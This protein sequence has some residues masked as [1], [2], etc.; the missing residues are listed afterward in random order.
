[1]ATKSIDTPRRDDTLTDLRI[2]IDNIDSALITLLAER[3][4]LTRKVGEFKR[5]AK[6]P[7]VDADRE[8]RQF[9]TITQRAHDNGLN[10]A[11]AL[12]LWRIIIDEVVANHLALSESRSRHE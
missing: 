10:S 6:L 11:L 1:M 4:R 7:A 2:S 5:D 12:K 3:F 9:A 8:A